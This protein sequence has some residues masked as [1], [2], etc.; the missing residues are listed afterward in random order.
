[1]P[2]ANPKVIWRWE[3]P[4]PGP[5]TL[6]MPKGALTIAVRGRGENMEGDPIGDL[7]AMFETS[8]RDPHGEAQELIERRFHIVGTG[9]PFSPSDDV[10]ISHVGTFDA[11]NA[12]TWHIF[13]VVEKPGYLRSLDAIADMV[14]GGEHS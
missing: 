12:T 10:V 4:R 2:L 5:L 1:M 7:W 14:Y 11:R 8:D 9:Q 3:I 6:N 13:A